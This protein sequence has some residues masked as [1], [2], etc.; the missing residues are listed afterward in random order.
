[1]K[2][3]S[4]SKWVAAARTSFPNS[5]NMK[6]TFSPG[7]VKWVAAVALMATA[8][9][10]AGVSIA[11]IGTIPAGKSVTIV[12]QTTITNPFPAGVCAIS[13]Q[14]AVASNFGSTPTDDP[15]TGPFPDATT[16]AVFIAPVITCPVDITTNN[17]SGT[18]TQA[19]A[20]AA[21]VDAGCPAPGVSYSISGTPITSPYNFPIGVTTVT[22]TAT[23]SSGT[24]TC[25][26]TVTVNEIDSATITTPSGVCAGVAGNLAS[27]P[28]GMAAY[29]W[30]IANGAITGETNTSTIIYTPN[31]SGSVTLNLTVTKLGGCTL[32]NSTFVTINPT[33]STPSI[34]TSSNVCANATNIEATGSGGT[35][36]WTIINGTIT[37]ATNL[38]TITYNAGASGTVKLILTDFNDS[39]CSAS[40]TNDITINSLPP[41]DITPAA[42]NI[43]E[44]STGNQASGPVGLSA[45]QWSIVNGVITSA[46]NTQNITYTAGTAGTL[47]LSLTTF[48]TQGCSAAS[49]SNITVNPLPALPTIAI[50]PTNVCANSTGNQASAPAAS[51]YIWTI[52]NGTITSS[53]NGQTI[54]YTAGSSGAV[55]LNLTVLNAFGCSAS[56]ATNVP[57]SA[58]P[59]TPTIALTPTNLCENTSGNIASAPVAANYAWT[60]S[61]GTITSATNIQTITYSVTTPGSVTLSVAVFNATGCSASGTTN[62]TVYPKPFTPTITLAPTNICANSTGNQASGPSS[63]QILSALHKGVSIQ[64]FGPSDYA[65]TD[66][67]WTIVN[68]TI[69]SATNIQTITYTAGTSGTV[70]LNLTVFNAAGCSTS[71]STNI[72]I[73]PPPTTATVGGNQTIPP[74]GTTT[75]LGGNTPTVGT[76][77]WSLVSGG[78]GIFNPDTS[79]PGATFTHSTG[80]GPVVVRWTI[81]NSPC[82]ASFANVSIQI[83]QPPTLT[84]PADTLTNAPLN[85]C[86]QT[87]AF[88]ATAGG[89][90]SPTVTYKIGTNVITSPYDFL[91]GTNVVTATA[92]NVVSSSSCSFVVTVLE[93]TPPVVTLTGANPLTNECHVAFVDPGATANDT[94][95]GSLSVTIN[96]TVN[97]NTV[98]V[99]TNTYIAVGPTGTSATNSRVIY[100]VDRTAP[101]VNVLGANPYTNECHVAFVDP[102]ATASDTCAGALSVA[103]NN[104][105]NANVIGTYTIIYTTVDPS[106]NSATNTRTVYVMDRTAP[107][108]TVIGANPYTNE[109]HTAFID[110]GASASD[111]CSITATI[112]T[113]NPVNPNT[114]GVYTITYIATDAT[115]NSTTNTRT[116]YVVDRTAPVLTMLG[117]NPYTNECH[118]TFI[119]P[120]ATASD[121]C[122][123]TATIVTN[124]LVDPNAV[125]AY[126]ITYIATDAAG[127]STTNTRNVQIVDTTP[128]T[129][130]V[131]GANPFTNECHVAFVDPG[132][133]ANDSCAGSLSVT[134]NSNVDANTVGIYTVTYIST[135]PNGNSATNTRTVYVADKT[136]PVITIN[137]QNPATN[138]CHVAYLDAGATADDS[139]AGSLSVTSNNTVNANNV[140]VYTVTYTSTDPNGNSTTNSRTVYVTD[141]TAPIITVL[142]ANPYTNECHTAFVD[143]G[144]T[145]S[146][147]CA[148]SRVITTNNPVNPDVPGVYTIAYVSTD[149]SGNSATNTRTVYVVDR[150]K[151]TINCSANIMVI[152]PAGTTSSNVTFTVTATDTCDA[153]VSVV[154]TPASGSSFEVGTTTVTST[155]TDASGNTNICQFTIRVHPQ[156]TVAIVAPTNTSVFVRGQD[157]PILADASAVDGSISRVDFYRNGSNFLGSATGGYLINW[158]NAPVGIHP[159]TAVALDNA[160]ATGTSAVVSITVLAHPLIIYISPVE[161]NTLRVRQT[162][163]LF[164][165]VTVSNSTPLPFAAV[166]LSVSNLPPVVRVWNANGTN[167]GL[168]YLLHNETVSAGGTVTFTVEYYVSDGHTL[169][170]PAFI[171]DVVPVSGAVAPAGTPLAIT[172]SI[173]LTDGSFM[174]EFKTTLNRVYYV[175]YRPDMG[176][177]WKTATP[178][179][180]G[181]GTSVQWID[182]GPSKTDSSPNTVPQRFYRIIYLP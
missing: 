58:L 143:S 44:A 16:T 8:N 1:M 70:T 104:P 76:G 54:I 68:G 102:G 149:P 22:V 166:R 33:P 4:I 45:Y 157:I 72:S 121:T 88:A 56:T 13:S 96:N 61:G 131:L 120:G 108:L 164:Q 21:S 98:G 122:S 53:T 174:V 20:F 144:A 160:G 172:K 19:V 47:T 125:G 137:G 182:S 87:V 179:I 71:A 128:P 32:T 163:L 27:G 112:T 130:T 48:S 60:I 97:T 142:G 123:I 57:V 119:D 175:Q 82:A 114:V 55:T 78:T 12:Y 5:L 62:V 94:C 110:P 153:G 73:T 132:A 84:C 148:G 106:G 90:P 43:C 103:T 81:T 91:V 118:T 23:N 159:L 107:V 80:A 46:T 10:F 135:D 65:V 29:A 133:T 139:C 7:S 26:F 173:I 49:F 6:K 79:T 41:A 161:T 136:A 155:A 93:T 9:L 150:T 52:S 176:A 168:P 145:S 92:S 109:C 83:G 40:V 67:S 117:A 42:T 162:G 59:A 124:N 95:A 39:G 18:C 113:N 177:P 89:L 51:A 25:S 181:N 31:S 152:V 127:N 64:S 138:E 180:I 156:P 24:N 140:G 3:I 15:T 75:S 158:T 99:Y 100:V 85:Q 171:A 74:S 37:S 66:Y 30:T 14:G 115:G 134:T 17:V 129:V 126:T 178:A 111:S 169:P 2:T 101:S 165:T 69:T 28:G 151:P 86:T 141:T 154:N 77:F 35:Y 36:A 105:V 170:N 116:V 167:A 34:S 147:S 146:D 50:A 11:N 38:Q 63:G